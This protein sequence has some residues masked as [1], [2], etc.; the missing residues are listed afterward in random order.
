MAEKFSFTTLNNLPNGNKQAHYDYVSQY[1]VA[2]DNGNH[3]IKKNDTYTII[4]DST[5]KKVYL[6]RMPDHV[7]KWYTKENNNIKSIT[8]EL[9]KPVFF[10]DFI[11]LCPSFKYKNIK[12]FD[13][14]NDEAKEGVQMVLDY[15]LEIYSN[16]NV[17]S[18][19]YI[20]KWFANL[21]IGNKNSTAL[22]L[23]GPKGIGK[24]MFL[25]FVQDYVIGNAL[26]LE[27]GSEPLKSRFNKILGGKLLV[28][29]EELENNGKNEW[30]Q[31]NSRLKRWITSNK[32]VLEEK[33]EGQFE[34][35][36]INN[37][38]LLSNHDSIKDD[39]G[40]RFYCLDLSTKYKNDSNYFRTFIKTCMNDNVGEAFYAYLLQHADPEFNSLQFPQ[41]Q[42]KLNKKAERL[43]NFYQ[44]LKYNYI[45]QGK[46]INCAVADLYNEYKYSKY[47]DRTTKITMNQLMKDIGFKYYKSNGKNKYKVSIEQL[48]EVANKEHWIHELDCDEDVEDE[49]EETNYE[50][51][52]NELKAKYEE[53]EKQFK[54]LQQQKPTV[55]KKVKTFEQEMEEQ[56]QKSIQEADA[57]EESDDEDIDNAMNEIDKLFA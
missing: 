32:I 2:L 28:V 23:M 36:N 43:I 52:Y 10:Q 6:N 4:D 48:K 50:D 51:K 41:T 18:H 12:P 44:F 56:I 47:S 13:E 1:F 22:Y 39:D 37:Y 9:N 54:L 24:S 20:I 15:L 34:S 3:A 31:I 29:F 8:Y 42:T 26:C 53:L 49:V 14:Y 7:R 46:G 25:Q 45:L 57:R 33:N 19:N 16:N 5:F 35:K 21:A 38:V 17:E 30:Y 27:T 55:V 40:R 11:N